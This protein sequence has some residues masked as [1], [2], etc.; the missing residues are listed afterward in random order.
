MAFDDLLG[1]IF[2]DLAV[3]ALREREWAHRPLRVIDHSPHC[4]HL[5][6][7]LGG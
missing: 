6:A 7:I 1:D 4:D 3:E 2:L 5:V